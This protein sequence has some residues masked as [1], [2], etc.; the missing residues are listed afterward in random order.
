MCFIR[1]TVIS[2][3]M[4][5]FLCGLTGILKA[6]GS[7]Q[8]NVNVEAIFDFTEAYQVSTAEEHPWI[9]GITASY[10]GSSEGSYW[11]GYG[12]RLNPGTENYVALPA[13]IDSLDVLGG[14]LACR[15][16]RCWEANPGLDELLQNP[17]ML[18]EEPADG[19]DFFPGDYWIGDE[20]GWV[21]EG[22]EGDGLFR[23]LEI[24]R[25][26]TDGPILEAYVGDVGPWNQ[27]DPYWSMGTRPDAEDG[28]DTRGRRT[29]GAGMDISYA[30]AQALGC[31]G[32]VDVDWRWKTIVGAYVVRRQVTEWRW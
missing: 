13:S 12:N 9:E 16:S 18:T 8:D 11:G 23:I 17:E 26:G 14:K 29:N 22:D 6:T 15:L 32:L 28:I 10:Y 4:L 24:K 19:V 3:L 20:Y 25:A 5:Y 21:I 30:L 2:G 31:S 7:G 1:Y 27:E